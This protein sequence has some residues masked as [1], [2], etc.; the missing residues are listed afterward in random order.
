M[1]AAAVAVSAFA[2]DFSA[3]MQLKGKLFNYDGASKKVDAMQLWYENGK[4]DKPFIF[5][6]SSDRVGAII[7]IFDACGDTALKEEIDFGGMLTSRYMWSGIQCPSIIST[8]L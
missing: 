8:P 5:S 7:K 4:D 2:V 3:G 6:L 1:A